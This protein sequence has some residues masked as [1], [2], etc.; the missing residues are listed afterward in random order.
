MRLFKCIL[1]LSLAA[2]L[3]FCAAPTEAFAADNGGLK[4]GVAFVT[5]SSLRLRASPSTSSAT[6]DYANRNE[7]VV[8]LGKVGSWYR[9]LF[10]LQEGYMHS[11]YLNTVTVENVELG[12]GVVNYDKVNMRTGPS[13]SYKA[14][15]QSRKGD[16]AYIIGIN[17]QWYKVIWNDTICYIRSDYLDLTEA[18]YENRANPKSPLFFRGGKTTGTP[19]S[20]TALK[21]SA[22]YIGTPTP[23][24]ANAIVAT[25]K[26]YIGVPYVWGGTS[27]SGFDCS[28]LVQYVFRQHGIVLNRTCVT[29]YQQ[30]TYVSKSN[31]QP[32]DLVFFQNTYAAGISHVGIYI[33]NGQFIHASSSKGV[34]VS[35]L[36]NSY[37][38]SHYYGARRVL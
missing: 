17:R 6:L 26:K 20:V 24:K 37:W 2:L 21:N 1:C 15:A 13:T 29:Q 23:N 14:I 38:S 10:N 16:R 35:D 7:V 34:M 28:G 18:P 3:F 31:L 36:S 8:L 4:T 11:D 25:A 32:G 9:V 19:V 22:N 12:Y 27:P 30:G 33:G 5:A